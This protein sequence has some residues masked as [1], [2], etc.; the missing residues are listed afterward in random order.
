LDVGCRKGRGEL[1]DGLI[2]QAAD[3]REIVFL[4]EPLNFGELT[5]AADKAECDLG[6]RGECPGR[7]KERVERIT[8]TVIAGI[9]DDKFGRS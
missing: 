7:L 3:I 2:R 4:G 1:F 8:G 6:S 5:A 9:H